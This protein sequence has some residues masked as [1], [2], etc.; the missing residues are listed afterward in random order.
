MEQLKFSTLVA[1]EPI[2]LHYW[3]SE[4]FRLRAI[5]KSTPSTLVQFFRCFVQGCFSNSRNIFIHL[6][7]VYLSN[8]VE[9]KCFRG[10]ILFLVA[11]V[12]SS[13]TGL[14]ITSEKF[15]NTDLSADLKTKTSSEFGQVLR[16]LRQIYLFFTDKTFLCFIFDKE[17]WWKIVQS[18]MNSKLHQIPMSFCW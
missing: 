2:F 15:H 11:E 18:S 6:L 9:Q 12:T 17:Y 5:K 14:S 3:F 10:P 4:I 16:L 1:Y 7:H 13:S 8:L